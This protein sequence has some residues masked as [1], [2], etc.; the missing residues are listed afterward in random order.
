MRS[1][2]LSRPVVIKYVLRNLAGVLCDPSSQYRRGKKAKV[3]VGG[4]TRTERRTQAKSEKG[5]FDYSVPVGSVQ[6]RRAS[7]PSPKYW[8]VGVECRRRWS[9]LQ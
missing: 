3:A 5:S 2:R 4:R 9:R 8:A 6:I 7:P 1:E